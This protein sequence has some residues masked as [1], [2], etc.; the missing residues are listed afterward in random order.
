MVK[1]LPAN[2]GDTRDMGLSPGAGRPPRGGNGNPLQYSCL[3][4]SMDRGAWR[5]I[6]RGV[7]KSTYT[8]ARQLTILIL[9]YI[10]MVLMISKYFHFYVLIRSSLLI[11]I[12]FNPHFMDEEIEAERIYLAWP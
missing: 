8:Q 7:A 4:N 2:A 9:H 11:C 1:N 3:E 12:V 10:Y 5:A 6:V